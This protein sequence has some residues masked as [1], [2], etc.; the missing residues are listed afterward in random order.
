MDQTPS[1]EQLRKQF[2][3]QQAEAKKAQAKL[4][5]AAHI[6]ATREKQEKEKKQLPQ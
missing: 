3:I 1:Q 6:R 5:I 4:K 2:E